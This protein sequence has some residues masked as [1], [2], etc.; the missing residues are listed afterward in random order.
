MAAA[1]LRIALAIGTYEPNHGGAAEW[2]Y[3]YAR[4]LVRRGHKVRI[5]CE[6]A[7]TGAPEGCDLRALP[8]SRHTKNSWRRAR[9]LREFV[10]D[11]SADLVHDT[12]C[13]ESS[14]IFHPLMGSLVHNWKRQ[15]CSYPKTLAFRHLWRI[16]SWRDVRLQF[17]QSSHCRALVACSNLAARDFKQLRRQNVVV[18]RNGIPLSFLPT[19]SDL[20]VLR[21]SLDAGDRVLMLASAANF[22]LKGIMTILRSLSMLDTDMRSKL[23][24]V[25]TGDNQNKTFQKFIDEHS[26]GKC[27]KLVGWVPAIDPYYHTADVFL[28]P[29]YHDAGSLSTLKAIHAGCAVVT[30]RF[31]GSAELINSDENGIVLQNPWDAVEL[32]NTIKRLLNPD[33]RNRL[34]NNVQRLVSEISEDKCFMQLEDLY[35]SLQKGTERA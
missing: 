9:V 5:I 34:R 31:D 8:P 10:S 28:H 19:K 18:I 22:Y 14:D 1:S 29:T 7:D 21:E 23:L 3:N 15:L 6:R 12:G 26:L 16:R 2:V 4:W 17:R 20:R 33:L 30:S 27:C 11:Y 24:V 35:F 13:L 32:A 25:V